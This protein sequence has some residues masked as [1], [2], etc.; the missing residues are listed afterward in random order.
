MMIQLD[1]NPIEVEIR[2]SSNSQWD[3]MSFVLDCYVNDR[4]TTGDILVMDNSSVHFGA[5]SLDM[6]KDTLDY[7][8]VRPLFLPTYSPELNPCELVFNK[9]KTYLRNMPPRNDSIED[10][11]A[12]G[13][14]GVTVH[15]I[16][17]MYR[18]CIDPV[19]ILPD[20]K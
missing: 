7:M 12:E 1:E 6:V 5:D 18:H 2:S 16:I 13:L 10:A 3:F 4:I 20:L 8:G 19:E 11:I 9:L 17:K 15:D 14:A